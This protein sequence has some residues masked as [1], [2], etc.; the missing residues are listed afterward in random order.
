MRAFVLF[1]AILLF[2]TAPQ[3]K[4]RRAAAPQPDQFEIGRRTF[5]DFGP[6]FNY[7]DLFVVRPSGKGTTVERIIL[8][9]PANE[10]FAPAKF[11]H[12]SASMDVPPAELLGSVNPCAIPEQE[13]KRKPKDCKHCARFSGADVAIR[14]RCGT[15]IRVIPSHVFEDYWFNSAAKPPRATSSI[16]QLLKRLDDAVGPGVMDKPVFSFPGNSNQNVEP[17]KT[18]VLQQLGQGEFD[19][20]FKAGDK[21]SELYYAALKVPPAP[22]VRLL[23]SAPYAPEN[24]ALPNYPPIAR[25][26]SVEGQ[27]VFTADLDSTGSPANVVVVSGP[28]LLQFVVRE[29]VSSWKFSKGGS[30]QQ[31]H[32]TIEFLLNC[33]AHQP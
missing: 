12:A 27:V 30:N 33:K 26:A 28:K 4:D 32:G 23:E 1:C 21:P 22:S 13:L 14:V 10:C 17:P 3:T 25:A 7:Y 31:I 18:E 11:E 16:L 29:A 2:A 6:P 19:G 15:E 24:P 8:T 20:L 9:P 5:W